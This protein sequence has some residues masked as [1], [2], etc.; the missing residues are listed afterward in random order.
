MLE[1]GSN[2]VFTR[3][4][5][6]VVTATGDDKNAPHKECPTLTLSNFYTGQ[7]C[8]QSERCEHAAV[9]TGTGADL[10]ARRRERQDLTTQPNQ[11]FSVLPDAVI[12]DILDEASQNVRDQKYSAAAR[13]LYQCPQ[14]GRLA[15]QT[16]AEDNFF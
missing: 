7:L 1:L 15:L 8:G 14:C 11:G 3:I 2:Q 6:V 16:A 5:T 10:I 4:C 13:Q 12:N 9:E